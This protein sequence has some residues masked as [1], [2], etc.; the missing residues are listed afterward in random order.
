M[1]P[2]ERKAVTL[3]QQLSAIRNVQAEKRRAGGKRRKEVGFTLFSPL[4]K[5]SKF[6]PREGWV[7]SKRDL[8]LWPCCLV[9]SAEDAGERNLG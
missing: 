3:Y 6:S 5:V 7:Y 9:F 8:V 4:N 2:Q 1:E